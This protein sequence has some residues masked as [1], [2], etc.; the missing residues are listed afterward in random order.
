MSDRGGESFELLSGQAWGRYDASDAAFFEHFF[1]PDWQCSLLGQ[2][3]ML[4]APMPP[5]PE[6]A[7]WLLALV[8]LAVLAYVIPQHP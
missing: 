4:P 5:I 1:G 2:C 7:S 3:A 8:G 6:P